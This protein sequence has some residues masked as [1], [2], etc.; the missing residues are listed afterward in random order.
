MNLGMA[1]MLGKA[2]KNI[3]GDVWIFRGLKI[4]LF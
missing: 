4:T 1:E 3:F 2:Q